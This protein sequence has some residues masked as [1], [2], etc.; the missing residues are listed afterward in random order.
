M[1]K[2]P[3]SPA[4]SATTNAWNRYWEKGYLHSCPGAFDGNYD[5]NIKAFWHSM[6]SKLAVS[7]RVLD[8][9]TGNGAVA[10]LAQ[11]FS[12]MHDL[13]LHIEG[14][15]A[16][17]IRPQQ[18]VERMGLS[19]AAVHF[20]SGISCE[21]TDY[22][23]ACMDLVCSQYAIEYSDVQRSLNEIARILKPGGSAGFIVHHAD[24]DIIRTT[25]HELD[26]FSFFES[27]LSV[28]SSCR[29]FLERLVSTGQISSPASIAADPE[30]RQQM[31]DIQGMLSR[32]TDYAHTHS[33]V[34][35]ANDICSQLANIL[36]HIPRSGE[37][38]THSNLT[39][40]EQEMTA[41]RQRIEANLN[42]ALDAQ[43]IR[44]FCYMA[45][46]AGMQPTSPEPIFRNDTREHGQPNLLGWI[47]TATRGG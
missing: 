37:E 38:I 18:A 32:I 9:G 19:A 17:E 42:A 39:V 4:P 13:A 11:D 3:P 7:N 8:I 33:N 47:V 31:T 22:A 6:F 21:Q 44:H 34:T 10:L 2:T 24:A 27:E 45:T 20:R 29:R 28:F 46:T 23:D 16:A 40:L 1:K 41:H 25:R 36:N 15:D 43:G 35:F 30:S 26:F 12:Q 14:I 5:N